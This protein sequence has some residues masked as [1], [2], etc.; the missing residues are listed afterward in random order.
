MRKAILLTTVFSLCSFAPGVALADYPPIPVGLGKR[1]ETPAPAPT[2]IAE[3][4][5]VVVKP[6]SVA[7]VVEPKPNLKSITVRA[8][9]Q[10]TGRV[11]T[12]TITV[13]AGADSVV[14]QINVPAGNYRVQIIGTLKS[15]KEVKWNAGV[16]NVKK[17]K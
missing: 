16:Q 3:S 6:G 17:K 1:V 4:A 15:G 10:N 11:V 7:V 8:I 14:P 5:A 2:A 13:S 12:R 9:N